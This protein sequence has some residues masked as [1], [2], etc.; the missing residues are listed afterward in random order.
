MEKTNYEELEIETR[1]LE[2]VLKELREEKE[3][4]YIQ[5]VEELSKMGYFTDEKQI[6]KWEIGIEYPDTDTLYKISELYLFPVNKLILAKNN[7][8]KNGLDA[9]HVKLIKWICYFTGVSMTVSC[10][11]V[12]ITIGM[13]LVWSL[14]FFV[15]CVNM[16]MRVRGVPGY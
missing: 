2:G 16:F 7:S 1:T 13:A 3:W 10:I 14:M 9:I 8:I 5:V 6:K 15:E 12:Y 4:T 11:F